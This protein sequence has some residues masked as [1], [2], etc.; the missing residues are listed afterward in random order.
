MNEND[1]ELLK[2][3]L[4]FI[5]KNTPQNFTIYAAANRLHK[6]LKRRLENED[7]VQI[8]DIPT[9]NLRISYENSYYLEELIKIAIED[10]CTHIAFFHPDSF[11]IKYNWF[12]KIIDNVKNNLVFASIVSDI[13]T[14]NKPH[15]S[16]ILFPIDFYSNYN[17]KLIPENDEL[18]SNSFKDYVAKYKTIFETGI[19]YGY[20]LYQKN[21]PFH[22]LLVSNKKFV[23]KNFAIIYDDLIFH[24]HA[25]VLSQKTFSNVYDQRGGRFLGLL[26]KISTLIFS[27]KFLI[28][29]KTSLIK[30]INKKEHKEN[31][32]VINQ[33]KMELYNDP[34]IFISKLI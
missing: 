13:G 12:Q 17:P 11:P 2:I 5:K 6:H 26:N 28:S 21:I 29:L 30:V 1:D 19:G 33:I 34:E 22:K 4:D 23:H 14:N 7:A 20:C 3:H 10:S 24:L 9:T 18:K 32:N 8:C 16:F 27:E 15:S 25:N 31:L